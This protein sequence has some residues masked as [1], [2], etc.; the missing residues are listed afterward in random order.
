MVLEGDGVRVWPG[1]RAGSTS[2]LPNCAHCVE[3]Y[4]TEIN[5][6][7]SE[8]DWYKAAIKAQ[9]EGKPLPPV[10]EGHPQT[11]FYWAK[12]SKDGGRIPV[13][14]YTDGS[15]EKVARSGTR[16][17]H[18]IADAINRWT[19]VASN[20]VPRDSYVFSWENGKWPD[21]TPTKAPSGAPSD[22]NLPSDPFQAVSEQAADKIASAQ[23]WLKAHPTVKTQVECDYAANLNRELLALKK[24]ADGLH[25]AEKAPIL[26]AERKIEEKFRFRASLKSTAD[27]LKNV[28]ELFMK[29]EDRRKRE[30]AQ[31][32]HQE[33]IAAAEAERERIAAERAKHIENDPVSALTSPEPEMPALPFAPAP[34]KTQAGGGIGSARGLK[35]VWVPIIKDHA[36]VLAHFANHP[37]IIAVVDKIVRAEARVH[38]QATSIPGVEMLE[39]KKVA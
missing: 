7:A 19:W 6:M 10:S 24:Q 38:K 28:F 2:R 15:G 12:A 35:T 23:A 20:P 37:D 14:I 13:C 4:I 16:D 27:A 22:H 30:E 1:C 17:E 21:G 34:V 11:G 32:K 25:G 36:A 26:E 33:E 5:D 39:D 18:L 31:R 9:Q 3:N 8:W 29:A